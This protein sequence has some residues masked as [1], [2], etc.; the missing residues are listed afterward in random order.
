M[1]PI[2][3]E[4]KKARVD[5]LR[6]QLNKGDII[7]AIVKNINNKFATIDIGNTGILG[8]IYRDELSPNKV[9]RASDE[10]FQENMS[11]LHIWEKTT[12]S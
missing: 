2:E 6:S 12:A 9:I 11:V 4:E 8:S 7:D 3:A 5:W 1:R 10:V